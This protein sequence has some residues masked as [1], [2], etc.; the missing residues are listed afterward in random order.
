MKFAPQSL[1]SLAR[2]PKIAMWPWH[3]NVATVFAVWLGIMY[4]IMCFKKWSLNAKMFAT[5]GS[6]FGSVVISMLVKSTRKRSIGVV[7][8]IGCRG[9]LDNLPS[10]SKQYMQDFLYLASHQNY[11]CNSV[12]P[13]PWW[14]VSQWHPFKA[15]TQSAL[16]IMKSR[17]SSVSSLGIKCRYKA[18][19]WITK[20]CQLCKIRLPSSLQA[21][22][23][24]STIKSVF[25]V[26]PA[27]PTLCSTLSLLSGFWPSW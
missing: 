19:W 21:C 7:D 16:G 10:C 24:R 26:P 18:P 3:K 4:A 12:Q 14:P 23:A 1:R 17:R 11:S 20:F 5:L 27:S 25:F 9:T 6:L 22:S 8:M 2:T 13:H 15:A